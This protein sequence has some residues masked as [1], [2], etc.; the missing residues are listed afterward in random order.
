MLAWA[1]GTA[2][3]VIG[4]IAVGVVALT[5]V[6]ITENALAIT[7]SRSAVS[8][9]VFGGVIV[10][11]R[12]L[13]DR[14][15]DPLDA[16]RRSSACARATSRSRSASGTATE[17]GLLQAGFNDMVTGL[18]EREQIRDLFG[19]QVGEDVARRALADES[20]SAARC[21]EVTVLF[22][23]I[24]GSTA[25][26]RA[27][28]P[29]KRSSRCSTASSPWSSTSSR[30]TAG[31]INKFQGDAALAI[32]GAPLAARGRRRRAALRAA[33]ELDARLR[34]EVARAGRRHRRRLRRG[35]RRQHRRRAPLRVH[36]H[37]RP[38]Q[39]GGPAD[40]AGQ[41]RTRRAC[42]PPRRSLEAAGG[43]GAPLGAASTR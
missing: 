25:P 2:V 19:R 34:A 6:E 20:R 43:E 41:G 15:P 42:S 4:L 16:P 28:A 32:F 22:V 1:L 10:D 37:R 27:S 14:P 33:R 24:V 35:R 21:R 11:A 18:R 8:A 5:P 38:G 12:L 17:I 29:R 3:P 36:G 26:G 7:C 39:R 30:T 9:C 23:D 13:R 40:R 31:W